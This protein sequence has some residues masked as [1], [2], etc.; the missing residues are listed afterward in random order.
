MLHYPEP[1]NPTYQSTKWYL[2]YP[3][4]QTPPKKKLKSTPH[5]RP[6]LA[7]ETP[8]RSQSKS[9]IISSPIPFSVKERAPYNLLKVC[10]EPRGSAVIWVGD[11][12]AFGLAKVA[13]E[14]D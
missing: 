5:S 6:T 4:K 3:T 10:L 14:H 9:K 1:V 11:F 2:K 13:E 8:S 12:L 7:S